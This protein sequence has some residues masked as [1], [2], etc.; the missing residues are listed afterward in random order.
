MQ[1]Y[2]INYVNYA[3]MSILKLPRFVFLGHETYVLRLCIHNIKNN[4]AA[5]NNIGINLSRSQRSEKFGRMK[6]VSQ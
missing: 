3:K 2:L 1:K 6:E 5:M 4:N